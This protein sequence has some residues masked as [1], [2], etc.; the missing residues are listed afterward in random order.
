MVS[1]R[2]HQLANLLSNHI[3]VANLGVIR[4]NDALP[5]ELRIATLA[6]TVCICTMNPTNLLLTLAASQEHGQ[7]PGN[8]IPAWQHF[9]FERGVTLVSIRIESN[10]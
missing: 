3:T 5:Y 4:T 7:D 2:Y 9:D 10:V 1:D 8:L 6:K